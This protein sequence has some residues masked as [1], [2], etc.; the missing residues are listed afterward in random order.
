MSDLLQPLE[1]V[2]QKLNEYLG[3]LDGREDERVILAN[4]LDH[5]NRLF[6]ETRNKIVMFLANIAHETTISTYRPTT[7]ASNTEYVVH[8]P[9]L[10]IN[11]WVLFYANFYD[12]SYTDGVTMISRTLS[13]FQQNRCFTHQNLAS[14]AR[15]ID[16]LS[17][18]LMNLDVTDLNYLMGLLGT[19]YLPSVCYKVRLIPFQSDVVETEVPAARGYQTPGGVD[20]ERPD[21][22]SEGPT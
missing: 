22:G 2:R 13:F 6:Q 18:D 21:G 8:A 10:R 11:V 4:V 1:L 16:K 19:H 5:D 3:N 17:F 15:G 9:P 12:K 7:P 20:D 14:L